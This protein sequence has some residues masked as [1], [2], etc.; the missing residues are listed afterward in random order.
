MT[1]SDRGTPA[2]ATPADLERLIAAGAAE[3]QQPLAANDIARLARL[4]TALERWNARINLT[5]IRRPAD[6]VAS[7]VLDSLAALPLVEGNRVI[8]IG[9]GAGFPGLPI[10]IAAPHL[11]VTLLDSH[12]KKISFVQHMIGE[13]A[14]DNAVAVRSR[15]EEYVPARPFDTVIAR[16]FAPLPRMLALA[17]HLVGDTGALLALKGQYPAAEIAD[18]KDAG[19]TWKV[20]VTELTVPGLTQHARHAVRLTRAR[21]AAS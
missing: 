9:C 10:A 13:L 16:A 2:G 17:G 21:G 15:V 18:L 11:A 6:M 1:G 19:A 8:D 14:L 20:D 5:A 12:G 3:L 7:H 4:L